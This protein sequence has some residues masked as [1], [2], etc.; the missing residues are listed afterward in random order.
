MSVMLKA[1]ST[2]ALSTPAKGM[3]VPLLERMAGLTTTM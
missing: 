3:P 1:T 2:V